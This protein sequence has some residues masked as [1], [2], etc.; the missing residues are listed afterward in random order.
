MPFRLCA[1]HSNLRKGTDV[2]YCCEKF[3]KE[4]GQIQAMAGGGFAYPAE[5]HPSAQFEPDGEGKT[6]NIN[7]CCG[8]GCF[9]VS[10][11]QFCPF[12][13]TYLEHPVHGHSATPTR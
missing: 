10:E 11:M 6:W 5:F 1:G 8:G 3:A 9:V 2:N 12:C 4:A 7:G 13:G